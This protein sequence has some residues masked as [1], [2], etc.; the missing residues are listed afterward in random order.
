MQPFDSIIT[1]FFR[2]MKRKRK[3]KIQNQDARNS[4]ASWTIGGILVLILLFMF[5]KARWSQFADM[6]EGSV[7]TRRIV[8]PF[9]F[10]ILKT[11]DELKRDR[12][13]AI[14]KVY[15]VFLQE[16]PITRE[17]LQ[18]VDRFFQKVRD[19]RSDVYQDPG[20]I[21]TLLDTLYTQYR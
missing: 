6:K 9:R 21:Q 8:A 14:Q 17:T 12:D 13:L 11:R 18:D 16:N 10:E 5:P 20:S 7:S 15:P 19:I 4:W 3:S 1:Y 2:Q